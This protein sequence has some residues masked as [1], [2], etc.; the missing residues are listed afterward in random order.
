MDCFA[1]SSLAPVAFAVQNEQTERLN[2]LLNEGAVPE[3]KTS[4]HHQSQ[5]KNVIAD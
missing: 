3:V 5:S 2:G 1:P 4:V